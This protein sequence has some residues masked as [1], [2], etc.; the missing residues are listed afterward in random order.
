M[1]LATIR[2]ANGT[3]AV[4]LDDDA[5]VD[6]G[7]PDLVEVLRQPGWRERASAA[8]GKRYDLA[9]LRYAPVVVAPEKIICI[10][11]NYRAHI[12]EMGREVPAHPTL[13]AKYARALIGAFDDIEL[14]AVSTAMDWE[15]ELALV[16]GD[17][18]RHATPEQARSAIAGFT[19]FNDVTVRDWQY[20][21]LQWLQGKTFEAT[22]PIGPYL[23]TDR[24]S[25]E[26]VAYDIVCEV[27]GEV[28]QRANT[29]DL[30]F[31][32]A[33]L[34]AYASTIMTLVPGDVIATGTPGGVGHARKPARYL[35]E[36]TEV[37]TRIAGIGEL[38]N[39][40]RAD[41]RTP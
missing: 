21:T 10:G 15:A 29:E 41:C 39:T 2:T 14:P 6:L 22:T 24:S 13:F 27:D 33:A 20:R 28:V 26:R 19:V 9:T 23:V 7:Y 11:I 31:D 38:R 18:V 17:T 5:A 34:V 4:R 3:R 12:E 37:V 25:G 32:P 8:T 30:V 1:K 35:T 40:C 16:I 36:G